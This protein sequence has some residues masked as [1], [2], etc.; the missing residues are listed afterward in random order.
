MEK[1][2]SSLRQIN[3]NLA[4]AVKPFVR[5][6]IPPGSQSSLASMNLITLIYF[7]SGK[8]KKELFEKIISERKP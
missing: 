5:F 3:F 1:M 6:Q 8:E 2:N 7:C 4:F